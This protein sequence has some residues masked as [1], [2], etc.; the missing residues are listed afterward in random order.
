MNLEKPASLPSAEGLDAA[1]TANE[2]GIAAS[3][4]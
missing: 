3:V 4:M 2:I 1:Y